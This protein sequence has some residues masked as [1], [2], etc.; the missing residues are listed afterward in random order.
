MRRRYQVVIA[1]IALMAIFLLLVPGQAHAQDRSL[2]W[3]RWD[4]EIQINPDGTF[5]VRE[6]LEIEFI[7]GPFTFGFR[8]VASDQLVGIENIRVTEGGQAYQ[9]SYGS[10]PNTFNYS[11]DSG[12]QEYVINWYYPSTTNQTRTFVLSYDVVG[13]LLIDEAGDLMIWQVVGQDH[14]YP[15]E[16]SAVTI[17]MPSGAAIDTSD[18]PV[19][20]GTAASTLVS[21]DQMSVSFSATDIP[22]NQPLEVY[23]RFT[24]GVIPAEKPPWQEAY[25]WKNST[26]VMLNVGFVALGIAALVGGVLGVYALW[27]LRGRD[28]A[29][30]AV[31]EYLS[32][33]PSDVPPGL[34]GT[35]VDEK[36]DLQDIIATL[37]DLARRGFIEMEER[38]SKLFGLTT[39]HNYVYRRLPEAGDPT[40]AYERTLLKEIFGSR[41]EVDLDDLRNEFY[42]AIPKLERQM[43]EEAVHIGLFPGSPKAVRGRYIALGIGGLV[44]SVGVGFCAMGAFV[45]Q[46][47]AVICPFIGLAVA[48]IVMIVVANVMPTKTQKGAEEAAKWR[49]FKTFLQNAERHRDLAEMTEKFDEYLPYAIAF[50]L[51]RTWV[52]KF[53]RIASTPV[54]RW[55]IP[56]GYG[57][58]LGRTADAGG[59]RMRPGSAGDG[60]QVPDLRGDQVRPAPSLDS[61]A[62]GAFGGLSQMSAG[63]FSMLNTT[64]RVFTSVPRSSG[65]GGFSGGGFSSGG[66]SG[67]GF[68][69]GGSGGAGFG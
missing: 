35:L 64:S 4:S 16:Q 59:R 13:A 18:G 46:V 22:A 29:V 36:A 34:V 20:R 15:I 57:H 43:Y 66:F 32:E 48:S 50:G 11:F 7:G 25:E 65:S 2:R 44:L 10:E 58:M 27:M 40:R 53:A 55:Y 28:P 23:I 14:A 41:S 60:P 42:T 62:Q 47:A 68:S 26:G 17:R 24:H 63:L 12:A 67:G 8:N 21:G 56:Y 33:P 49:A 54:P 39:G 19:S 5:S 52:S 9:Q 69:A 38:E 30:G 31:P 37:V 1:L 6:T 51:E 61:M 3:H 45:E